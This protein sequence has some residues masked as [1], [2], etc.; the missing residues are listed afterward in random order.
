MPNQF[1]ECSGAIP[2]TAMAHL[3]GRPIVVI[4]T[5]GIF[6]VYSDGVGLRDGVV[7]I[8]IYHCAAGCVTERVLRGGFYEMRFAIN[9]CFSVPPY[10]YIAPCS[11][12]DVSC[13]QHIHD[14]QV[15]LPTFRIFILR[16]GFYEIE[17]S[18]VRCS[19]NYCTGQNS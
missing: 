11:A 1:R 16:G 2:L 19:P 13:A 4:S 9:R 7:P 12:A 5:D 10:I 18:T 14:D 15:C 6:G 8:A 17:F 3:L